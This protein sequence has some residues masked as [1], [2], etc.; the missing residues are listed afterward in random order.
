MF[1]KRDKQMLMRYGIEGIIT[2][3]A[4]A[5]IFLIAVGPKSFGRSALPILLMS[6]GS[7]GVAMGCTKILFGEVMKYY[8]SSH[9]KNAD[10]RDV[11]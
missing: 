3:T 5:F 7:A 10:E 6:F 2:A 9:K 4:V 1:T 11:L 8:E